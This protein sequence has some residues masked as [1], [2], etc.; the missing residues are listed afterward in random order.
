MNFLKLKCLEEKKESKLTH[1]GSFVVGPLI[2]GQGI[3]IGNALRRTLLSNV[4]GVAITS[5]Q[6]V[7]AEHEYSTLRGVRE[8]VLEIL[9]NLKQIVFTTTLEFTTSKVGFIRAIGPGSILAK[10]LQLPSF[11][12]PVDSKQYIAT[13]END[14]ELNIKITLEQGEGY[15]M[16]SLSGYKV[17]VELPIDA[18]F[19]PIKQVNYKVQME[20]AYSSYQEYIHI[21]IWTNGSIS[22]HQA[23]HESAS[24]LQK[25]FEQLQTVPIPENKLLGEWS[26]AIRRDLVQRYPL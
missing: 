19:M 10:D 4:P 20:K 9:S 26:Y 8:S 7:G 24:K 1:Y 2:S 22:P 5:V 12:E 13:L 25:L 23:L 18:T 6:I 15:Q 17:P 16:Q 11:I 14:G 3:T 21:E